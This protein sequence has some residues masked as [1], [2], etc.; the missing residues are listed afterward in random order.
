MAW[1]GVPLTF[2]AQMLPK[3]PVLLL[4]VKSWNQATG[5]AS[6]PAFAQEPHLH[7]L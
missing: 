5:T 1:Q 4:H 7:I 3:A 2:E 6:N